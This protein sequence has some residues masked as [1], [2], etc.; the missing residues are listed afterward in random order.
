[1]VWVNTH[2]VIFQ[3]EGI[4]AELDMLEFILVEVRPAPQPCINHMRETLP[5]RHLRRE[6]SIISST[7][8][9][10]YP[11]SSYVSNK[12]EKGLDSEVKTPEAELIQF[13]S[14]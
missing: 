5:A 7:L 6:H 14:L 8:L 10:L 9:F 4:L 13:N 3:V 1:M 2:V 11:L 12:L